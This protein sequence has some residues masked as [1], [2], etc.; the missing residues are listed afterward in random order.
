[1]IAEVKAAAKDGDSLGGVA[2]VIAYGVPSASGAT[3]TG[4][5]GSTACW[6]RPS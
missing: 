2:E 6:P 3:C 1:M 5:A 4:T